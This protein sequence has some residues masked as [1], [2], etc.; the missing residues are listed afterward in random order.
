L[1]TCDPDMAEAV[2]AI[3]EISIVEL[4][5]PEHGVK[6]WLTTDR[7]GIFSIRRAGSAGT[8]K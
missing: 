7:A 3:A 5:A 4:L 2:L 6:Q 1:A 8:A